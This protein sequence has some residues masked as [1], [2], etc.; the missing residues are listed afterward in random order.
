MELRGRRALVTG[1]SGGI[2]A[3]ISRALYSQ[4]AELILTGRHEETLHALADETGAKILPADLCDP[5]YRQRMMPAKQWDLLRLRLSPE[6][7][8]W[9]QSKAMRQMRSEIFS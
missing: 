9:A 1:A 8:R 3:A 6:P 2:G 7:L 4:G 5:E